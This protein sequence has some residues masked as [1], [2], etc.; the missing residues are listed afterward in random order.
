MPKPSYEKIDYSVRPAKHVERKMLFKTIGR[1]DRLFAIEHYRYIGF[2]SPFFVDFQMVHR[3][4]GITEMLSIEDQT[5]D[6]ERF[7]FNKPFSC[8]QMRYGNSGSVLPTL[9]WTER[10]IVWL[11]YD[12]P[13]TA[14]NLADVS[15]LALRLPPGSF[16]VASYNAHPS[17]LET[18]IATLQEQLGEL[19]VIGAE[20]NQ[21]GGWKVADLYRDLFDREVEKSL[22]IR[23][24]GGSTSSKIEYRQLF[25]FCYQDGAKMT[26]I[27]G[28]IY[29]KGIEA[30]LRSCGFDDFNWI[31]EG[32]PQYEIRVPNLTRREIAYLLKKAPCEP[33]DAAADF[34]PSSDV[35]TFL[36]NYRFFPNYVD[37]E[38]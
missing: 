13:M 12:G 21:F 30:R 35:S 7:E 10:S 11:D 22:A 34:L 25:N 20:A 2:G 29:D 24:L 15:L 32:K 38:I 14:E 5:T 26:T 1:V 9:T 16:L 37:V 6:K 23:N 4:L 3:E 18:R 28:V 27:G 17:S 8:V 19:L 33:V 36:E 31:R